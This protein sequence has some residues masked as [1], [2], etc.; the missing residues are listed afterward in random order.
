MVDV[1]GQVGLGL[2]GP[3]ATRLPVGRHAPLRQR[4]R[5]ITLLL[6]VL[7]GHDVARLKGLEQ[8]FK[9]LLVLKENRLLF[10]LID[11]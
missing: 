10:M 11:K 9:V 1:V 8:Q 4:R 5:G 2:A 3:V 6:L 7:D